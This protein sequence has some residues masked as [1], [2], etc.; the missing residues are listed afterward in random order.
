MLT[1]IELQQKAKA[2]TTEIYSQGYADGQA[3][4]RTIPVSIKKAL[5]MPE[6][7]GETPEQA[8]KIKAVISKTVDKVIEFI[9]KNEDVDVIDLITLVTNETKELPYYAVAK[10]LYDLP[11]MV[12]KVMLSKATANLSNAFKNLFK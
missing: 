10:L 11:Q 6:R 7:F 4:S 12:Q 3:N 9:E 8:A 5:T 2:F 1:S